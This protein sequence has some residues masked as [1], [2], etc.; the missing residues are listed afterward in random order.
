MN[1]KLNI[2]HKKLLLVYKA[3]TFS[4]IL[5]YL[6]FDVTQCNLGGF[7]IIALLNLNATL[8]H[9]IFCFMS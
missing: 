2:N 5:D 7:K 8:I 9:K 3:L 4:G 1:I 6:K